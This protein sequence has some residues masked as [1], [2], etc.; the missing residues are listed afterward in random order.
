MKAILFTVLP[1]GFIAYLPVEL[2]RQFRWPLLGAVVGF[3]ALI[4]FVSRAVFYAGL[5][6]YESGN[7]L[8]GRQ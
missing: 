6:R 2:L 1:A 7:L 5:R 4:V 8:A 3:A